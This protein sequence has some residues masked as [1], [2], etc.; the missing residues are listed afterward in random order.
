[1]AL[2]QWRVSFL[3][4]WSSTKTVSVVSRISQPILTNDCFLPPPG[5][6]ATT[7]QMAKD[8]VTF[9]HWAAEPEHDER[10]KIGLK[11]VILFSALTAISLYV[12]RA[13][14]AGIKTRK[15]CACKS[16]NRFASS[17]ADYFFHQY[18]PPRSTNATSL[19]VINDHY[20]V[21]NTDLYSNTPREPL[22]LLRNDTSTHPSS[23]RQSDHLRAMRTSMYI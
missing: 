19:L 11:A 4:D 10:K 3:T 9:L 12:K 17:P 16:D 8:V 1:M 22:F 14:W 18:T 20:I 5:T 13:K 21:E 6:P 23:K 15:I 7:S 2:F